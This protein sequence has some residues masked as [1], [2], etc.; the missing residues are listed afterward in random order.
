MLVDCAG[1]VLSD[2][3]KGTC[4][5]FLGKGLFWSNMILFPGLAEICSKI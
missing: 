2:F 5:F 1:L 4:T 3:F